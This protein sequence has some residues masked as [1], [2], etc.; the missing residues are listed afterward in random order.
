MENDGEQNET[1]VPLYDVIASVC[2]NKTKVFHNCFLFFMIFGWLRIIIFFF[3]FHLCQ[4]LTCVY[5]FGMF[6]LLIP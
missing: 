1:I 4:A 5:H 3:L 2:A 6:S